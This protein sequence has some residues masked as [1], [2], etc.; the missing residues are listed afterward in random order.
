MPRQ[1]LVTKGQIR[2]SAF[3]ERIVHLVSDGPSFFGAL[4]ELASVERTHFVREVPS[5]VWRKLSDSVLRQF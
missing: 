3:G 1:S 4:F 2:H 5:L